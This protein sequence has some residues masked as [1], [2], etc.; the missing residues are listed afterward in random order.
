M[1][2]WSQFARGTESLNPIGTMQCM[3]SKLKDAAEI[4]SNKD[5]ASDAALQ[6]TRK[7]ALSSLDVEGSIA[8]VLVGHAG[9]LKVV[10]IA[11]F[12]R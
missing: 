1:G 9:Q 4:M 8:Y 12:C 6:G 2:R 7:M 11:Q 5:W 10:S 3:R